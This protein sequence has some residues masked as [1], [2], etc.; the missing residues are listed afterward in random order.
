MLKPTKLKKLRIKVPV[1]TADEW[2]HDM[3]RAIF[4]P[5]FLAEEAPTKQRGVMVV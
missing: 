3:A 1:L 2:S 5:R 4:Q